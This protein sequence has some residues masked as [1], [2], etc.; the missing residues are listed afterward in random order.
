MTNTD[1]KKRCIPHSFRIFGSNTNDFGKYKYLD[2]EKPN[3]LNRKYRG[4]TLIELLVVIA[5]MG[6]FFG[7]GAVSFVTYVQNQQMD[8][9][10]S[11]VKSAIEKAKFNALSRVKPA[12]PECSNNNEKLTSYRFEV[13]ENMHGVKPYSVKAVC[14]GGEIGV[15]AEELPGDL[16]FNNPNKNCFIQFSVISGIVSWDT[17]GNK[18]KTSFNNGTI[19]CDN[20]NQA[21]VQINGNIGAVRTIVVDKAGSISIYN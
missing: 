9:A 10:A 5:V 11:D 19:N 4:F 13:T 17:S 12:D 8:Q 18:C 2:K 7:T 16:L 1:N 21:C 20:G 3:C 6:V 15:L 14:T